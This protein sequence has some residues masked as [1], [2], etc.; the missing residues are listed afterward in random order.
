MPKHSQNNKQTQTPKL[1]HRIKTDTNSRTNKQTNN[2][3]Q[4]LERTAHPNPG[5]SPHQN[6]AKLQLSYSVTPKNKIHYKQGIF[7]LL[8]HHV[9]NR[10][11]FH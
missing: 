4:T 10:L 11:V 8:Q 1:I 2:Q 3:A 7:T 9:K 5:T 6:K